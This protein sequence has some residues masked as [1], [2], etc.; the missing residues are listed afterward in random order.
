VRERLLSLGATVLGGT[1]EEL[2]TRIKAETAK[3]KKVIEV[4]GAKPE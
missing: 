4:S 3:W 1:P 2:D